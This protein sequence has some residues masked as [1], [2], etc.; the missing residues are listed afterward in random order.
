MAR[1]RLT[2]V[3]AGREPTPSPTPAA[4]GSSLASG[5]VDGPTRVCAR[6]VLLDPSSRVLLLEGR[7]L[8]DARDTV[9]YWF[10]VGGALERGESLEDAAERELREETGRAG[11]RLAGPFDRCEF[12]YRDHGVLRH[13][14]EHFFAAR[15]DDVGLDVDGWTELERRAVTSW[16]WWS[17]DELETSGVRFFPEDLVRIVRRADDLLGGRCPSAALSPPA[18]PSTPGPSTSARSTA[19]RAAR[20]P[21]AGREGA[22]CTGRPARRNPG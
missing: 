15:T 7:D 19:R 12:D 18:P 17:A 13:Q 8:S 22:P 9:R 21:S 10:T 3:P 14:V 1:Q 16:R 4:A 5:S 2:P 20:P 6:V 11:L